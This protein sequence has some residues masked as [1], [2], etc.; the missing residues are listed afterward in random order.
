MIRVVLVERNV[1]LMDVAMSV[2]IQQ[3]VLSH[4]LVCIVLW[5]CFFTCGLSDLLLLAVGSLVVFVLREYILKVHVLI[6][7]EHR[8]CQI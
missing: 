2:C 4:H 6:S 8:L 3:E 5:P 7:S 1:V